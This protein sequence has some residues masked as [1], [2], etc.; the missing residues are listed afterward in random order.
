ML[1]SVDWGHGR[2]FRAEGGEEIMGPLSIVMAVT[3]DQRQYF[4]AISGVELIRFSNCLDTETKGK[5]G[6]EED[7]VYGQKL[8]VV[9]VQE[10]KSTLSELK[11]IHLIG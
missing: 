8:A 10:R 9:T 5:N 11:P 6:L 7:E 1:Q 2:G 4:R 3:E